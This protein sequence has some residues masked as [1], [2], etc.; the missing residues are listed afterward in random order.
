MG[1]AAGDAGT[2]PDAAVPDAAAGSDALVFESMLKGEIAA[3]DGI[4]QIAASGGWPI[5]TADG[6]VFA[7]LDDGGGPYRIAGDFNDW[8]PAELVHEAGLFWA[9][10]PIAAPDGAKYKFVDASESF[11]ADPRSRRYAYDEFGEVSLVR[12]SAA[13]LERWF[14]LSA[15]AIP[16]RTVRVWVPATAADRHLYVH[17][18]QNLFDPGA[19]FGGWKLEASAGASTLVVGIDNAGALRMEEY[20]HVPDV[21]GGETVGGQADAYVAFVADV[22]RPLIE[23]RYGAPSKTGVM[24]SSLGGLVALHQIASGEGEWDFAASLSG[25]FG[26]GSIGANNETL[27]ERF[28]AA[29]KVPVVLY[30]DSGGGPGSGCADADGDG[31]FDDAPD[32]ADNYCETEQMKQTLETLGWQHDVDLFHWFEPGAAHSEA[33]W[34]ARVWRP[35]QR[36][37]A[38]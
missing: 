29:Q 8:S 34:A 4:D 15:P 22:V 26:W 5:E 13:H 30:L 1:G 9:R 3:A 7:R 18:G 27:I 10:L 37:E 24:G 16:A 35:L 6:F 2:M 12:S 28:A 17:D 32:S 19:P 14:A 20:T 36:F 11:S 38:L 21:I 23:A 31:I 25:T 33:A